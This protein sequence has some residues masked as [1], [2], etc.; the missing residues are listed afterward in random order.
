M[1]VNSAFSGFSNNRIVTGCCIAGVMIAIVFIIS[2][3]TEYTD[4]D[5]RAKQVNLIIRQ[6]GHRLLLQAGDSTSRV[7]P[8]TE[9]KEGT[10]LLRFENEFVFSHDSLMVMSQAYFPKRN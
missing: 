3:F 7:L 10:F 4:R 2:S 6:I 5:L 9:S 8:V 1:H